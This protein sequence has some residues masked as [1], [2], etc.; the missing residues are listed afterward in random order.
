MKWPPPNTTCASQSPKFLY[1]KTNDDRSGTVSINGTFV[2]DTDCFV[3]FAET[4]KNGVVVEITSLSIESPQL[5]SGNCTITE[6]D[7]FKQD[8]NR[9]LSYDEKC[10]WDSIY[11]QYTQSNRTLFTVPQCGCLEYDYAKAS[12]PATRSGYAQP[13]LPTAAKTH[14]LIG[15][16]VKLIVKTDGSYSSEQL[17]YNW[18]CKP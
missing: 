8:T 2:H 7:I 3:P 14:V 15:T 9:V 6:Y 13:F 12:C 17:S 1:E 11:F 18:S 5:I 4:C 16:D 10:P